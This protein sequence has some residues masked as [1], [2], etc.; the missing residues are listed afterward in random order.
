MLFLYFCSLKKSEYALLFQHETSTPM[1]CI[2][3]SVASDL[4]PETSSHPGC[5][6]CL[7]MLKPLLH[8][9]SASQVINWV[10]GW[11]SLFPHRV[12]PLF[13]LE[14]SVYPQE[15][16]WHLHDTR[17]VE[18]IILVLKFFRP[19]LN[20]FR[21]TIPRQL[22]WVNL[23]AKKIYQLSQVWSQCGANVCRE[24]CVDSIRSGSQLL[25]KSCLNMDKSFKFAAE[26]HCPHLCMTIIGL[27]PGL[28]WEFNLDRACAHTY[29]ISK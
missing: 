19:Y 12:I 24:L 25:P 3:D 10:T 29:L 8:P 13:P 15:E 26:A 27:P 20:L 14:L 16:C 1:L 23:V 7:A 6:A 9:C 5:T 28:F 11:A 22:A 18:H 17:V 21:S 2:K 4:P